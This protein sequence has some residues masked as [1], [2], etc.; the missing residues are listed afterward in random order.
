MKAFFMIDRLV[1]DK[2]KMPLPVKTKTCWRGN[3]FYKKFNAEYAECLSCGTLVALKP[4]S[5]DQLLVKNDESDFYGKKYWLDHQKEDLGFPDIYARSRNDLTERNLHWLKV[6]LKY[7]IPPSSVLELGCAHGSLVALLELAGFSASGV[8]MSP[9]VAEFGQKTFGISVQ[10]GVVESLNI[11]S[12]SLDVIALMDVL[13]HLP[14][15]IATMSHCLKLLKPDGLL[16][17]QTPQFK[18]KM[19]Y[20]ELFK[21]KSAFLGQLK[22]DEHLFLFTEHSVAE[23]F[24]RLGVNHLRFEQAIFAHY[25]MF[26]VVS[27]T[28]LEANTSE[29][30]DS[31]LMAT[32]NGRFAQALLDIRE[33]ELGLTMRWLE[34]EQD[35]AARLVQIETLTKIIQDSEQKKVGKYSLFHKL[36]TR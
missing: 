15:P 32:P 18:E 7:K 4:L 24:Q 34:S 27:R 5:D 14:D 21:T 33:R 19:N 13:E 36:T 23:L 25:D 31:A 28:P 22:S 6:L 12:G 30:V 2:I 26:F 10:S 3:S 8:E 29:Q 17:I 11:L 35:R 9:W 16:L 1:Q 20:D